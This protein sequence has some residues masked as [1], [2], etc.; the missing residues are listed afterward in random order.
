MV[1]SHDINALYSQVVYE[2]SGTIMLDMH[3]YLLVIRT[4][5]EVILH[6]ACD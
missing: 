4:M 5:D 1:Y 2:P 6:S 3:T